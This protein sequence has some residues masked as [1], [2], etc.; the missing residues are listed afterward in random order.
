MNIYLRLVYRN[1]RANLDRA[2]LFFELIF[3][4]FFIFV[5]GFGLNGI[6]PPFEIGNGR[7]VSYSLFLAAGAV[8]LTVINGGTNAGTQLWF[9]RKNGMFEQILMGPFTRAQYILSIIFAT[10]IIG[11]AGSLLVF[12]FA[13]PVLGASF[14]PSLSGVLT[15]AAALFLGTVFFGA[16]AITLSVALK[17]SET[18]Q[19]VSTF[20]FF[21]FLF[22]SSVFF[23]AT[24]APSAIQV[25]SLANPLTYTTDIFRAGLFNAMTPT[26]SLEL[27]IL[28]LE[29][30]VM[31]A[32]AVIAFHRIRV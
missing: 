8:T 18:F 6:V 14:N 11:V 21:I 32:I 20:A 3:P 4:L 17:S 25:A 30:V 31:F 13:F 19:I 10:L 12:L 7:V 15:I 27:G 24:S 2:S 26:V 1:L 29:A 28:A 5:Q 22:T 23:P 16:F 9:D